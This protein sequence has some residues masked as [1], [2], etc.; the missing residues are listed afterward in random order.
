MHNFYNMMFFHHHHLNRYRFFS[1]GKVLTAILRK[2]P[3]SQNELLEI[4]NR[5]PPS[6][7]GRSLGELHSLNDIL[8][9]LEKRKLIKRSKQRRENGA[10]LRTPDE[11]KQDDVFSLTRMGEMAARR[12]QNFNRHADRFFGQGPILTAILRQGPTTQSELLEIV[13]SELRS[14]NETLSQLEKQRLIKRSKQRGEG[15]QGDVFSLTKTGEMFARRFQI[16]E[17]FTQN[18]SESLSEGEKEQLTAILEK[19]RSTTGGDEYSHF[20]FRGSH[21]GFDDRHDRHDHSPEHMHDHDGPHHD[22]GSEK[23]K[24]GRELPTRPKGRSFEGDK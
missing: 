3:M 7:D 15:S 6:P 5:D 18:I 10:Q 13:D 21:F 24:D 19:L 16:H 2:G 17:Y 23:S 11:D 20:H 14:L 1:Q 4:I 8:S 12:F 9:E 22:D